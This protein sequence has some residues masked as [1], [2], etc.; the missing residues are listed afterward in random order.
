MNPLPPK[1]SVLIA[2]RNRKE[3][4]RQALESVKAQTYP[5]IEVVLVDDGSKED[6]RDLYE[7][8]DTVLCQAPGGISEARNEAMR[9]ATGEIYF[10]LDSDDL[11][12]PDCIEKLYKTMQVTQADIVFPKLR[13]IKED[14]SPSGDMFDSAVQNFKEC[15]H[16]KRIPHQCLIKK[17][18]IGD[19]QYDEELESSVDYD[20]ILGILLKKPSLACVDECLYL[21]REHADRETRNPRQEACRLRVLAKYRKYL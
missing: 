17:S 6:L 11:L 3:L 7:L 12:L 16:L 8:C 18:I 1:I 19:T 2:C 4:L 9:M 5:N 15:F 21:H 10:I 20:F 14:G 13:I